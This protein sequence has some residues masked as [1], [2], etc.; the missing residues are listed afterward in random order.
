ML[1]LTS[2]CSSLPAPREPEPA[3]PQ[4][5]AATVSAPPPQP[6]VTHDPE[7]EQKLARSELLLLEKEAQVSELQARLDDAR[8]EVVRAMAKQ[9]SLAS[10]AEAA[11]GMAEAEIALQSLHG[12]AGTR[13]VA[14]VSRLI[15]LSSAEF[16]KQNYSGAL[17]LASQAKGA[18]FAARGQLAIA[19][20]GPLRP[21]EVPFATALKLQTM[22]RA[23]VRDGPGSTFRIAYTL[24]AGA[25]LTGFSR[26][27]QWVRITDDS[28][29]NGWIYQ[30]LIGRRP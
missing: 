30:S 28:G 10:R 29:R 1:S 14:E 13:G 12:T 8:Q 3:K 17:Y 5:Q 16:D 21:G 9:Q 18:A 25:P 27:E 11:S 2:A 22:K 4:D 24:P 7:L 20:R 6:V 26:A 19:D 15:K 23:N